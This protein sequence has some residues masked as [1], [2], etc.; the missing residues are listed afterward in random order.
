LGTSTSQFQV[1]LVPDGDPL[2]ITTALGG[3]FQRANQAR[4]FAGNNS[5][6][7]TQTNLD[8][9]VGTTVQFDGANQGYA[10]TPSGTPPDNT[11]TIS[12]YS[13]T[14]I[15]A[16]GAAAADYYIGSMV[17]YTA[18]GGT[19]PAALVSG[20]TYFVKTV[21]QDSTTFTLTIAELPD[22]AA[23]TISGGT[24]TTQ[25]LVPIGISIDKNIVHAKNSSF[26]EKDMVQ[27]SFPE[28]GAIQTN[29][30]KL[31]YF[32]SK[33]WD[34]HNFLLS[35]TSFVPPVATGGVT[36]DIFNDGQILRVHAFTTGT[37]TFSFTDAG[38][39]DLKVSVLVVGGG[40]GGSGRH[41]GG[42]GAGGLVFVPD[43]QLAV[44]T[45]Y[46]ATVGAGGATET[47]VNYLNEVDVQ[48]K[49]SVFGPLTALGGGRAGNQN[50][51]GA[52]GYNGRD[53]GSG[54]GGNWAF[55]T[56]GNGI[57]PAQSGQSGAPYGFGNRGGANVAADPG[58]GGGGG[59][60]AGTPGTDGNSRQG[61]QG[62]DGLRSAIIFGKEYVFS[63]IFGSTYGQDGY[64]AGGGGGGMWSDPQGTGPGKGGAGGGGQGGYATSNSD[65]FG[66][67]GLA[68]TGGGGGG[69]GGSAQ[70][71]TGGLGGS[72]IVLVSYPITEKQQT[73]AVAS[74]GSEST[75]TDHLG[76][77]W[78][79]HRFTNTGSN[80]FTVQSPGNFGF[81]YLLIGG[82]GAGGIH[83]GGG[84]GGGGFIE[85]HI[86]LTAQS[87]NVVVGAGGVGNPGANSPN[88][89]EPN[90]QNTTAF[91]LTALG[92]GGGGSYSTG[93]GA[94]G[95]SAGGAQNWVQVN[96]QQV[97]IRGSQGNMGGHSLS[98]TVDQGGGGGGAGSPGSTDS[99][100]RGGIGRV[101]YITGSKVYYAG[102]GGSANYE[103]APQIRQPNELGGG[104]SGGVGPHNA[105]PPLL[106]IGNPGVANTGGG[107][108]G[109]GNLYAT[110]ANGGSG[111][112][113]VRYPIGFASGF[114]GLPGG[115]DEVNALKATGG[116]LI[117]NI[118]QNNN[119]YKVHAFTSTGSSTFSVSS[120]GSIAPG[121]VEYLIV[122]GGG[123]GGAHC[124][125]GGGAG[126]FLTGTATVATGSLPIVVGAG[127]ARGGTDTR[128]NNGSNSTALGL[129]A[130]G[131]G[132]GGT[133]A[134]GGIGNGNPGGSGG[135]AGG[136]QGITNTGGAGTAGQGFRGGNSGPRQGQNNVSGA[137]GGGAGGST[138][139]RSVSHDPTKINGGPGLPSSIMGPTFW[140]AGGGGSG[141][142]QAVDA[143]DGGRGGGGGGSSARGLTGLG[144]QEDTFGVSPTANGTTA[145]GSLGYPGDGVPNSGGGGGGG[146]GENS[147]QRSSAGGSGIVVIRYRIG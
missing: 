85:G 25:T 111:V 125:G 133:I 106:S 91:G 86:P 118:Y 50:N 19:A 66:R 47:D 70:N 124:G 54:G 2:S 140:F 100:R 137:G 33:V 58:Y 87:Y 95:G 101:S 94:Q 131:G 89:N 142:Y 68:N 83:H 90:G 128:G 110:G 82:G 119:W 45:N 80:T 122:G 103:S 120:L 28:D 146:N 116:N 22:A 114:P 93:N 143:G 31:F 123:G 65:A 1:S 105:S 113:I 74:G 145:P 109:A 115:I 126:G 71:Q 127:G 37:S 17:R 18:T 141:T 73:F 10:G 4:T 77:T 21:A 81:E 53:G 15:T 13:G 42:G 38:T 108:G 107:G 62:G 79:V 97:P 78:K 69:G 40:A 46:T 23:I 3:T 14:T 144:N 60:G 147:S 92:G 44:N 48:G 129:T 12:G 121:E 36:T 134:D 32:V 67:S 98:A 41:S 56:F 99:A 52:R 51:G 64:F 132:G 30:N 35:P 138:Q 55:G 43:L 39:S 29:N 57:Q 6:P 88:R 76:I 9:L 11:L 34:A 84:G 7:L 104:G 59:G 49:N 135:G 75:H 130:F 117:Y 61:G 16:T 139:D 112:A 20:N 26:V 24:A 136:G 102:G 63:D 96:G 72:G 8:V 5:N 27:Y